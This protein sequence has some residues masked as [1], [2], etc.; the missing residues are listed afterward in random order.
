MTVETLELASPGP[1]EVLVRIEAAGVC[2]SDW[3]LATGATQHP[4]PVVLG[5]EGAGIVEELGAGVTGL[6]LGTIVGFYAG[7]QLAR[8]RCEAGEDGAAPP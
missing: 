3:H 7:S 8:R 6:A 5:H 2:H 1:G 4:L